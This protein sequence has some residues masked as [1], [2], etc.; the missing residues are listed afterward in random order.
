[1]KEWF[2]QIAVGT[3]VQFLN[4]DASS[5]PMEA[6]TLSPSEVNCALPEEP[7]KSSP[8]LVVLQDTIEPLQD[9]TTCLFFT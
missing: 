1:M 2:P 3:Y 4:S 9:A 5:L 8:Q 7:V 6:A